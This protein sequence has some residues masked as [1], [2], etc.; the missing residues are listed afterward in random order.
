M[1]ERDGMPFTCHARGPFGKRSLPFVGIACTRTFWK[2]VPA[3]ALTAA[4]LRPPSVW[5]FVSHAVAAN[6]TLP[7]I[8]FPFPHCL[9]T[10]G[11]PP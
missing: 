8:V 4:L 3:Y 2:K 11:S 10:A 1:T 5:F 6:S 9:F 7:L